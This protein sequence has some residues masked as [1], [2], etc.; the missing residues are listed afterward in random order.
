MH[1]DLH[2]LEWAKSNVRNRFCR[3]A[4]SQ[5]HRSSPLISR[6]FAKK[7][8]VELLEEFITAVFERSLSLANDE[9]RG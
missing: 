1:A 5:V 4:A 3:S 2:G 7:V 9:F 8:R 6:F